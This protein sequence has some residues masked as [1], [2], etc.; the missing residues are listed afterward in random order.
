MRKEDIL[1][2]K[3]VHKM[4]STVS[5]DINILNMCENFLNMILYISTDT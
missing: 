5:D 4:L 1:L 3:I 2:R